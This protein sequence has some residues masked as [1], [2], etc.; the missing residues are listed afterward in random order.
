MKA[1]LIVLLRW[2]VAVIF[3]VAGITKILNPSTFAEDID[4]YRMLPYLLV[5]IMAIVLP[6]VE[7]LCGIFLIVGRPGAGRAQVTVFINI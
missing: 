2:L 4:N 3:I 7:V 5:T 6:M 1:N